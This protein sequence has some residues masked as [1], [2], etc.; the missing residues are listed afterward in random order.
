MIDFANVR[1]WAAIF[2]AVLTLSGRPVE[3]R[4]DDYIIV[5]KSHSHKQNSFKHRQFSVAHD[6]NIIPAVS[7]SLDANQINQL[8]NNPD[9][10]YIEPDYKIYALG[11]PDINIAG[12]LAQT[13]ALSGSQTIPYG[14]SMVNAPAIWPRTR[15]AGVRVAMLDTG[16]SISRCSIPE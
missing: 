11:G 5:Y 10:E 15:G 16:I 6:F 9:I 1:L 12:T 14:V 3:S 13:S 2:F 4:A 8:R 7:A